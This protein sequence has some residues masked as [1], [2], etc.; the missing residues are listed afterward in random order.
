MNFESNREKN[1]EFFEQELEKLAQEA[2]TN[3]KIDVAIAL[4][5]VLG[6]IKSDSI[7]EFKK[8]CL[9]FSQKMLASHKKKESDTN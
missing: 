9:E 5:T 2:E 3:Q 4:H 6:A 1:M 7:G 8:V